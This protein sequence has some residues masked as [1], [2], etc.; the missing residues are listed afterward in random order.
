MSQYIDNYFGDIISSGTN[1]A[2]TGES[3]TLPG[4]W[5]PNP[6][7]DYAH[8]GLG[9]AANHVSPLT[10]DMDGDA[11]FFLTSHDFAPR[12]VL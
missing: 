3:Y 2:A 8:S 9:K 5:A 10:I 11:C 4:S 12:L 1:N 7:F 6:S